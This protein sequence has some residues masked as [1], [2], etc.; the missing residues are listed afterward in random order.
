MSEPKK[1]SKKSACNKCICYH[2]DFRCGS[3]P[4]GIPEK[5]LSGKSV[6]TDIEDGQIGSAVFFDKDPFRMYRI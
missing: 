1:I 2:D 6:H 4:Y 3:F 5:F